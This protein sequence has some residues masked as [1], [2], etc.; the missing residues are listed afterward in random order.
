[1]RAS[2]SDCSEEVKVEKI[3][4]ASLPLLKNGALIHQFLEP[5]QL[6]R[7]KPRKSHSNEVTNQNPK[8]T[9]KEENTKK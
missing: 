6:H 8:I 3:K 9:F 4:S 5:K 7:K 1:M 2:E